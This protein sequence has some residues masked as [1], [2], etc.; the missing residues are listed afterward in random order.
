MC[1]T[2]KFENCIDNNRYYNKLVSGQ[3]CKDYESFGGRYTITGKTWS[4]CIK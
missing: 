3:E 1:K 2:R 4:D